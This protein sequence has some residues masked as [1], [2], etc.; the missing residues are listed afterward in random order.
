[1]I[2]EWLFPAMIANILAHAD[3]H[4]LE[5]EITDSY[6]WTAWMAAMS[7]VADIWVSTDMIA[8]QGFRRGLPIIMWEVYMLFHA[9]GPPTAVSQAYATL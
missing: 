7:Q 1:M 9:S 6:T 2:S 5:E 8:L 4:L 3:S